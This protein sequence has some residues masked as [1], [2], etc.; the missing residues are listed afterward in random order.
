MVTVEEKKDRMSHPS[1][2]VVTAMARNRPG[3]WL[4]RIWAWHRWHFMASGG[5]C[6]ANDQDQT[7]ASLDFAILPDASSRL[8]AS[9]CSVEYVNIIVCLSP[10]AT[11]QR[12]I[13][14]FQAF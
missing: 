4:S 2:P 7:P 12:I 13:G 10:H 3:L 9:A 6:W 8:S 1:N 11:Q 5:L 14:H